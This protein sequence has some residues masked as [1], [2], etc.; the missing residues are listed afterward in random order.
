[1]PPEHARGFGGGLTETSLT[2]Y[3]LVAMVVAIILILVLPRKY[4]A[5]PLLFINFLVPLGQGVVLGGSH[6]FV[7][8]IVVLAGLARL[9]GG[10]PKTE[11]EATVARFNG[12][13]SAFTWCMFL[14]A[15]AVIILFKEMPA[16][17]NQA[18]FLI[19]SLG[20]Y[21]LLR[22]FLREEDDIYRALKFLAIVT[23]ILA[24]C[25]II[26]QVKLV[27]VFGYVG[28]DHDVPDMR[29]GKIRSSGVFQHAITAGCFAATM[30]P[31]F[32]LLWKNGKAKFMALLGII[33]STIMTITSNSSTP[34]LAYVA[35]LL[36]V[37][38]WPIRRKMR[39]VRQGIVL[40]LLGLAAVMKAP[41]WFII[42]HI[43]LTGSSSGYHRAMVVD[44]FIRHFSDWWL[45]GVKDTGAWG[46][47]LWDTQNQF[48]NVGEQGGLLAFIFFIVLLSRC[49]GR[50]GDARKAIEDDPQRQWS[51]WFLGAALFANLMAFFGVNYF[52][53]SRVGWF[54]LLAMFSTLTAP[55]LAKS[56]KPAEAVLVS[57]T[58]GYTQAEPVSSSH[59]PS[60]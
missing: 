15:A 30:L 3:A 14:Q 23:T 37:G 26:E 39:I 22:C 5:L 9:S 25:M 12:I 4:A 13:D 53:Q 58:L 44:Q 33:G 38:L 24:A 52:D 29:D 21:F 36:A 47:D 17:I 28:G 43:D 32:L 50:M 18:G 55:I 45:I 41:V 11:T 48:V 16:I 1:M 8:R 6:F 2:P 31:L 20:T 35:G 60:S 42:A 10:K 40:G 7:S 54:M 46:W 19:D 27:N 59:L 56:K 34:L 57:S 49:F 51:L